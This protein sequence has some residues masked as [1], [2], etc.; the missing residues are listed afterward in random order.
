MS[1]LLEIRKRRESELIH[2]LFQTDLAT[3]ASF[4]GECD[5]HLVELE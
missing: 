1:Q 4:A 3:V 5:E 2:A